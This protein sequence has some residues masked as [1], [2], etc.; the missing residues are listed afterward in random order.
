MISEEW[1]EQIN[2]EFKENS[3]PHR[4]RAFAAYER[5]CLEF[6]DVVLSSPEAEYLFNWFKKKYKS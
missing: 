5:M 3:V 6:N 4:Q 2:K 1:I